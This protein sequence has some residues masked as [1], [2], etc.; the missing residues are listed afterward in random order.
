MAL[1]RADARAVLLGG[2]V[3]VENALEGVR[4][5]VCFAV[6]CIDAID[7][8]YRAVRALI[9]HCDRE[10]P[11]ESL[12]LDPHHRREDDEGLAAR[13]VQ[14][15]EDFG[16]NEGKGR[17]GDLRAKGL[18][19]AVGVGGRG[20]LEKKHRLFR[21]CVGGDGGLGSDCGGGKGQKKG[22]DE[23]NEHWNSCEEG[24]MPFD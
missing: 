8:V 22:A 21:C 16:A 1:C 10:M 11:V 5:I 20:L 13:G 19:S 4:I 12:P 15:K 2:N 23:R 24:K 18:G 6:L 7:A 3:A 17:T 14:P 9:D